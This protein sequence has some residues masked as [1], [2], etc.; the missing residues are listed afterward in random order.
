MSFDY[1]LLVQLTVCTCVAWSGT[2]FYDVT[3]AIQEAL[4]TNL[5]SSKLLF[6]PL[7]V[8]ASTTSP[9]LLPPL[10][11][12]VCYLPY[13]YTYVYWCSANVNN[14]QP[15]VWMAL[16]Y[17]SPI[18]NKKNV[19]NFWPRPSV[20]WIGRFPEQ[21]FI[22]DVAAPGD[23]PH[24]YRRWSRQGTGPSRTRVNERRLDRQEKPELC[25]TADKRPHTVRPRQDPALR[26]ENAGHI[27]RRWTEVQ[28]AR[29]TGGL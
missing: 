8:V 15:L 10:L 3:T 26:R 23:G 17:K 13:I 16:A 24:D 29:V 18:D 21:Q 20:S 25:R 11:P 5:F 2:S 12:L 22:P 28:C 9:I 19:V 4:L 14:K 7:R 27:L 1:L 6:L